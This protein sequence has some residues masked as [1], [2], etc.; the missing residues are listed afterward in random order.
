MQKPAKPPIPTK[1]RNVQK[2]NYVV[3]TPNL[4]NHRSMKTAPA[5]P[6]R[7]Q[8]QNA[9][10]PSTSPTFYQ[11]PYQNQRYVLSSPFNT[12]K[13]QQKHQNNHH[14][15]NSFSYGVSDVNGSQ[16][17][18]TENTDDCVKSPS[19]NDTNYNHTPSHSFDSSSSS[20]GGFR[21]VDIVAKTKAVYEIHDK[22]NAI[23]DHH[24]SVSSHQQQNIGHSK[25]QM[26][27][28]KLLQQQQQVTQNHSNNEEA[29]IS[30]NRKQLQKSTQELEKL[31]G[32][33]VAASEK[34]I[35]QHQKPSKHNQEKPVLR[36]LSKGS[37][38][39][40]DHCSSNLASQLT[41]NISK[42]IQHKLQQEM[43]QQ[44]EAIKE[45]YLIERVLVQ[46]HYRDYM[47]INMF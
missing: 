22:N 27:Q 5:P 13:T 1:P 2:T 25:V 40:V 37:D 23:N 9:F 26:I 36:M 32:M 8:S 4:E 24:E 41:L 29:V 42:Q 18:T 45:K 17:F 20:S 44:C 34:E 3:I 39:E 12:T 35:R 31:F 46:Q 33:R 28:S 16:H 19:Y 43:K 14:E 21:D 11:H 30:I 6:P 15:N 10:Y 7:N 38:D 47:V